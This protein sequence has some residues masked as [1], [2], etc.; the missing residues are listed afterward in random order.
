MDINDL[1][2]NLQGL[3]IY[4]LKYFE[5]VGSTNDIAMDWALDG[6]RDYSL[7]FADKQTSGR[8]RLGRK[9]VT[10]PGS[11]IAF[12][13][14]ISPSEQEI[15]S[16]TLFSP[17]GALAISEALN[18]LYG[19]KT[20]IKWPN[21]VLYKRSKFSGILV[22]TSWLNNQ[23]EGIII[24]IGINILPGSIP[25]DDTLLYPATCVQDAVGKPVDRLE[26]LRE[27]IQRIIYWRGK[28]NSPEFINAWETKLAFK[29]EW[30][31]IIQIK[32]NSKIMGKLLGI[33]NNGNLRLES[34]TG[35]EILINS[36]DLSLRPI[37]EM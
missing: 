26:I 33:D 19:L 5:S 25:P 1:K 29:G 35:D 28:F 15:N 21:D 8:G 22:E 31:N 24:G 10:T 17:L 16:I 32:E 20:E 2:R 7:V 34:K 4:D 30:V 36:G 13:L 3:P 14:I 37:E 9:W 12:S 23:I 11:A 27:I 18:N 6:A